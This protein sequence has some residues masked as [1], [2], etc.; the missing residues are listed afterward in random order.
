MS[1]DKPKLPNP[2]AVKELRKRYNKRK[3]ERMKKYDEI[4]DAF[5]KQAPKKIATNNN[6][7][8]IEL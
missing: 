8:D 6:L 2:N 7:S 5:K 1:F 4:A 3:E